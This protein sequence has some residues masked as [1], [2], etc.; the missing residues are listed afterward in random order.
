DDLLDV[1]PRR[2]TFQVSEHNCSRV[3]PVRQRTRYCA[4]MRPLRRRAATAEHAN[5]TLRSPGMEN[6]DHYG[7]DAILLHLPATTS[8][9]AY[10][11][12]RASRQ[13]ADSDGTWR[14]ELL[15]PRTRG[16]G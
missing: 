12:L 6:L 8:D 7:R 2:Q 16:T 11:R 1:Q 5:A 10:H 15:R 14:S 9:P 13:P 4:S 3:A